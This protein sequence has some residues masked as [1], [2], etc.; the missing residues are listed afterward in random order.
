MGDQRRE[1][2]AGAVELGRLAGQP[3]LDRRRRRG[4]Q[5]A[6]HEPLLG[7]GHGGG[8]GRRVMFEAVGLAGADGHARAVIAAAVG[9]LPPPTM[10]RAVAGVAGAR[11]G[12][13][14]IR[15]LLCGADAPHDLRARRFVSGD[16]SAAG[17]GHDKG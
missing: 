3:G 1:V 17:S 6:L 7:R 16:V 8:H 5:A 11:I 4:K 14:M 9:L 10:G 12:L 13:G 15:L 2:A